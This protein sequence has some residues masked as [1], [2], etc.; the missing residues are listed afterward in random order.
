MLKRR[1]A[2]KAASRRSPSPASQDTEVARLTRELNEALE[3]QTAASKVLQ[4]ISSSPGDLQPVFASMLENAVRICDA[5]FGGLYRWDGEA[6]H[7]LA[8]HNTPP[9]LA[10][11]RRLSAYRPYP[12][13]PVGRMVANKTLVHVRDIKAEEVYIEQRDPVA[14]AAVALGGIRTFLGIP[15]LN[16][17]EMIGAF[18]LNRQ[19][20]RPFT[21]KQIELVKNLRGW[22]AASHRTAPRSSRCDHTQSAK[23]KIGYWSNARY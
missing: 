12:H 21:G 16:K 17:G 7:H 11:D 6:L 15:L 1:K 4:V 18:F 8:S 23:R 3:Q 19:E 2:L 10:E 13:S 5:K 9:A 14:V 22:R 20:V